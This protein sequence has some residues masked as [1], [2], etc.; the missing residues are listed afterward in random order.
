M[1]QFL[2]ETEPSSPLETLRPGSGFRFQGRPADALFLFR[3]PLLA[4]CW[5]P[6]DQCKPRGDD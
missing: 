1:E 5:L 3:V 4:A 6:S 2:G